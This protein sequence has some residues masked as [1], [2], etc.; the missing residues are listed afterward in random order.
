M[1]NDPLNFIG[2]ILCNLAMW[3]PFFI[4]WFIR[5]YVKK[6]LWKK[7]GVKKMGLIS[8]SQ[9]AYQ[10]AK[11]IIEKPD[12]IMGRGQQASD[13]KDERT[14]N[15]YLNEAEVLARNTEI[16]EYQAVDFP[17]VEIIAKMLLAYDIQAVWNGYP[18]I[19]R[20]PNLQFGRS[21]EAKWQEKMEKDAT[22]RRKSPS[23]S[24]AISNARFYGC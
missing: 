8:I 7:T 20:R 2:A 16:L 23:W 4:A 9:D 17:V 18:D 15:Y 19:I 22:T 3:S 24:R 12:S 6:N 21:D 14:R 11:N 5:K 10:K 1:D 13:P